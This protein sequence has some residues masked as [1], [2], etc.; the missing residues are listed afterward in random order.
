ME[1]K[2]FTK[3]DL[4]SFIFS[5]Q[6]S[7]LVNIP[8]SKHR[9]ISQMNNP[10]ASDNDVLLVVQ[11]DENKVVGY[12]GVLP[13]YIFHNNEYQ[14]V[15][16]LS[17]FWIDE[18]YKSHNVAANLFRRVMRA[19]EQKI[20]ITN[21]VPWLEPIYQKT[22]MFQPTGY[23]TGIRG[24]MRSNLSEILPPKAKWYRSL[25]PLLRFTDFTIN[26]FGDIRFRFFKGYKL[27][28]IRYEHLNHV[29][30]TSAD[31]IIS[32]NINNW[33]QRGKAEL[34]W[35]INNPWILEGTHD[36][37][38]GS[39][40]YF[41]TFS[42]RFFYRLI[43]FTDDQNNIIGLV[44]MCIRN[45]SITIPYIFADNDHFDGI[46]KSLINNMIFLKLNMITS[47]N[48]ELA[49]CLKKL[50]VPFIFKKQIKKPYFISKKFEFIHE[51]NFQ[52]GDGDCAFY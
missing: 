18:A 48:E 15:G 19:W 37:Y 46:T 38:N 9:A 17:C 5:E 36:D 32:Y 8:I 7:Q 2:S 29:D 51:L 4:H 3:Q 50:K 22:G 12:L 25:T 28:N 14:K 31:Y 26:I 40:Y 1:T 39:R 47:F 41:S 35:I 16:W 49:R 34:E 20:L 42:R 6:F 27:K 33:N 11:F 24:Y 44:L 23:K 45:N 52:D 13:D 30:Q 10:R 43:K 21:I